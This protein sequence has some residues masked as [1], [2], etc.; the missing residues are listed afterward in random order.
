M[1]EQWFSFPYRDRELRKYSIEIYKIYDINDRKEISVRIISN[2]QADP[3]DLLIQ[4]SR[5]WINSHRNGEVL[6]SIIS[7]PTWSDF[8]VE[9]IKDH[10]FARDVDNLSE[11]DKIIGFWFGSDYSKRIRILTKIVGQR[12]ELTLKEFNDITENLHELVWLRDPKDIVEENR[13]LRG[14][15]LRELYLIQSFRVECTNAFLF[16]RCNYLDKSLAHVVNAL[17][18][19]GYLEKLL[20]S[21]IRLTY[22]GQIHVENI[23]LSSFSNQIF[24]IAAC[25]DDI[26]YLIDNVYQP[27]V[28]ACGYKLIFQEKTEAKDK[29]HD[30]IW[31]NIERCKMIICDLSFK[32]PNCYIEYGYAYGKEKQII[33][34]VEESQGKTKG[35]RMKIPFD[36]QTQQFSFWN[37]EWIKDPEQ[38]SQEIDDFKTKIIRRLKQ[39][40]EIIDSQSEI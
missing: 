40:L 16:R 29:I 22:Q 19:R 7:G 24:L 9:V 10:L 26:Y 4:F 14:L 31:E 11:N 18:D 30:A 36:T 23:L 5:T 17:A 8:L 28:E 6:S 34:M 37:K 39:K 32:R 3:I 35:N 1:A 38:Y 33:L 2:H 13:M 21:S 27:A 15:I 20:E 25:H 12:K